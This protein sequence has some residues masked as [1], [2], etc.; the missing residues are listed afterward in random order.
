MASAS[1]L[2]VHTCAVAGLVSRETAVTAA[3]VSIKK[4]VEAFSMKSKRS[5]KTA[6][7]YFSFFFYIH[8]LFSTIISASLRISI[9]YFRDFNFI[10]HCRIPE[11]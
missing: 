3:S 6:L 7:I 9:F 10:F 2:K 1:T 4:N 8:P 5:Y 11:S